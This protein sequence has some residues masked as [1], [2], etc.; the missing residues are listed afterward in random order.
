MSDAIAH[1]G[2][3]DD[4][5][6]LNGRVGLGFRRLSI[7]DLSGGHQPMA[8]ED[9]TV[10]I[11]YNGEIFNHAEHRAAAR[12]A[13]PRVPN[14]LRHRSDRASLRGARYVVPAPSCAACSDSRSGTRSGNRCCSRAIGAASSR[15]STRPQPQGDMVFG[16]EIKA[17]LASGMI[18]A[19]S[20]TRSAVAEYFALGSGERRSNAVSRHQ[21]ARARAHPQRGRTDAQIERYWALPDVRAEDDRA[22]SRPRRGRATNSGV[23][24]WRPSTSRS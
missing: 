21:E 8:N 9:E 16:S 6:Y 23:G 10:W 1:R 20:W 11:A 2:P 17:I 18:D 7:I 14:T 3:D 19:G 5:Q 15:C 24:L 4:G 22:R 12:G 13:R